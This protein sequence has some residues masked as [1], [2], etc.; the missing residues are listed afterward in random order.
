ME[1]YL[2]NEGF[3][4]PNWVLKR[5]FESKA[6]YD[7][8]FE[9]LTL[10]YEPKIGKPVYTRLYEQIML[11]RSLAFVLPRT[12]IRRFSRHIPIHIR[13]SF[14]EHPCAP[15]L[16]IELFPDQ[17]QIIDTLMERNFTPNL[18][19]A[20]EGCALLKLGAGRGKT[21][22]AAG[23]LT[24]I[25]RKCLYIVPKKPLAIQALDDFTKGL[26]NIT[27]AIW[28]PA[29]REAKKSNLPDILIMVINT[30]I[31]IA[32]EE[33]S[34]FNAH[35][36]AII[37][38]EVHEYCTE[39][40]SLIFRRAILPI[41]FGMTATPNENAKGLDSV[42]W[43]ELAF[44][45]ILDADVAQTQTFKTNVKIIQYCAPDEYSQA[46]VHESTEILF[47]HYM[48]R[49]FL[50]DPYR[51][52]LI[53]NEIMDLYNQGHTIYGFAEEIEHLQ[54]IHRYLNWY[55]NETAIHILA[56]LQT[57]L[58]AELAQHIVNLVLK[59][60]A[61]TVDMPE[62]GSLIGGIKNDQLGHIKKTARI[63]LTTYGYAGTGIS[64][65][66]AS[67]IVFI[68]PRK[69]KMKQILA[70][71]LRR[72]F[73]PGLVREVRDICDIRTPLKHQVN[74]RKESYAHYNMHVTE[75]KVHWSTL[76]QPT[77]DSSSGPNDTSEL[78]E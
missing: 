56:I 13:A 14:I 41:C 77:F 11:G 40:R 31:N 42:Y 43:R 71:I 38:D 26:D 53:T 36:S 28:K 68:T 2:T 66:H 76:N 8:F 5:M 17:V 44:G 39:A 46:L 6:D 4:V 9:P 15:Q 78:L 1:G 25:K 55:I 74:K 30:A 21:L 33:P 19:V 47:C 35:Y 72:G 45:G 24:Q 23:L 49:Q 67:A 57:R 65:N 12:Y 29:F 64:I 62:I 48:Y 70:R 50:S 63:I 52:Q 69:A 22:L 16:K 32:K 7:K 51:C 27:C 20:G 10:K 18:I 61:N 75:H 54:Q 60:S 59:L 37:Y 58:L 3:V 73:N 34:F